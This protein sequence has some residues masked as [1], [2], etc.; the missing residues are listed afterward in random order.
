MENRFNGKD[1]QEVKDR[2]YQL[3]EEIDDASVDDSVPAKVLAEMY[4]EL[5]D[6]IDIIGDLEEN[7][8]S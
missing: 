3:L 8:E 4:R 2:F 1:V 5:A 7:M 6:A